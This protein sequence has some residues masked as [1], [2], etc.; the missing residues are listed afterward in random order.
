MILNG[1]VLLDT[2]QQEN[3]ILIQR[4]RTKSPLMKKITDMLGN[5]YVD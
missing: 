2:R 3:E 5:P 4:K 1:Q